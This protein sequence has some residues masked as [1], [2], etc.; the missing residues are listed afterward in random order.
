[1]K[2]LATKHRPQKFDEIVSQKYIVD[3]LRRQLETN[4]IR[5]AYLFSGP[6]GCG[7][8]TAAR[9]FALALN[10]NRGE[11]IEI[12]AASHN[13]VDDV[14]DIVEGAKLRSL[15]SEYKI[16][17]IDECHSI[18]SQGWQA[19]LKTLE[20]PPEK[21]IFIFCTT[22]PEKIPST[23]QNRVMRFNLTKIP[24][25]LIK[26]RLQYIADSED[27]KY[28][29]ASLDY[30]AKFAN[31]GMRDAISYLEKVTDYSTNITIDNVLNIL[32]TYSYEDFIALTNYLVDGNEKEIFSLIDNIENSGKDLKNFIDEY[33]KCVLD[34][35]KYILFK[36]ISLTKFPTTIED[37]VKYC[38]SF[39]H[40]REC[41]NLI[42]DNLLSLKQIIRYDDN[43]ALTI[44]AY[45]LRIM[46]NIS[47]L[48]EK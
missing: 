35:N 24:T 37:K 41:F 12:D 39:E 6:S 14:R 34:L 29:D 9:C 28:D 10:K 18:T 47:K 1:M 30:I 44:K 8:T 15:D 20:E 25:S 45:I 43:Y 2:S 16:Y 22:N 31:G 46:M 5:N 23:I 17:I 13:G 7:K 4:N 42:I 48:S 32:G 36:D 21:T 19:F 26:E 27:F 33:L 3:I 11:P 40:N 38:I